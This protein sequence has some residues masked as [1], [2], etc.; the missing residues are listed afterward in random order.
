M[1]SQRWR[2]SLPV[3][4]AVTVVAALSL[5]T[6]TVMSNIGGGD[7]ERALV[8][9]DGPT[10]TTEATRRIPPRPTTTTEA[11]E[12]LGDTTERE[13]DAAADPPVT[14]AVPAPTAA[15]TTAAPTPA[16]APAPVAP[17]PAP[18]TAPPST[19]PPTTA[20]PATAPPT[21]VCRN[22]SDPSCGDLSWD[23]DP[24]EE[25]VEVFAVSTP[26][27]AAAGEPVTFAVD[28][29]D[30]AGV[31]AEGACLN[32]SAPDTGTDISA[33]ETIRTDCD[34]Y[35]PHD[36]PA[37]SRER[38]R[39]EQRFTFEEPGTYE[40]TVTGNI[41][42]HLADGCESPYTNSFTRTFTVVVS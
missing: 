1:L 40:V 32:W 4:A 14:T 21:T 28:Y 7:D 15:P 35:G 6:V 19:A 9:V 23:P 17:A 33:C 18:T 39:S 29:I 22:S 27:A 24:D 42:T 41:A 26:D 25:A 13:P 31:T 37:R 20:P 16:P 30:P 12:V 38:I 36:P 5:L 10:T 8:D 11:P 3:V 34:R 2:A